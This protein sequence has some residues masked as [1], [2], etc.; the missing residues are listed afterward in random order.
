MGFQPAQ[1]FRQNILKK[2]NWRVRGSIRLPATTEKAG[3][4]R[5]ASHCLHGKQG[6]FPS[7]DLVMKIDR[8]E[9]VSVERS[10]D[11]RFV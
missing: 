4:K 8:R 11:H 1:S 9:V 3:R 7:P 10:D 2:A 6:G 5:A